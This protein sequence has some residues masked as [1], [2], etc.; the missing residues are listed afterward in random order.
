MNSQSSKHFI[1]FSILRGFVFESWCVLQAD[2]SFTYF[3]VA[4]LDDHG[5]SSTETT[6]VGWVMVI[7]S[8][9]TVAISTVSIDHISH[10][11]HWFLRHPITYSLFYKAI[12]LS[13]FCTN[14]SSRFGLVYACSD[15]LFLSIVAQWPSPH[16]GAI[17][18][19]H[20]YNMPGS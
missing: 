1:C 9:S 13:R 14:C 20:R 2:V 4:V 8:V 6:G 3:A 17:S 15:P 18:S 7:I 10:I 5:G 12:P 19:S 16:V 11:S